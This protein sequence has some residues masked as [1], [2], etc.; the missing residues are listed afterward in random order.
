MK[1]RFIVETENDIKICRAA[2]EEAIIKEIRPWNVR[3][4]EKKKS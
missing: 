1:Q 3:A 2:V 4:W